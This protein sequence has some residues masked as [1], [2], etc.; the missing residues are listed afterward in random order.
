MTDK[1]F[2]HLHVHTEFSLLDGSAK[3]AELPKR[4]AELGM[5]SLAITDHGAMY[6]V[7]DFYKA[8]HAEG[9]K[10]ILGCE[11]YVASGSCTDK[12]PS[13]ENFY[14]HL[15]LLAEN[16]E[17]YHNLVK[18]V[19]YGFKEGFYYRPRI[20]LAVLRQYKT[21]LIALSACLGGPVAKDFLDKG[22]DRAKETA[23]VYDEI[24]GRGNFYLELQDHGMDEQAQLN[25]ELIRMSEETG[26]PL[27]ATND[28][29]YIFEDDAE[30][31]DILLCIQ[32]NKTVNDPDRMS[33]PGGGFYL[34]SPEEMRKKFA[35]I[36]IALENT[37]EIADRC[38]VEIRFNEYKLPKFP[39]PDNLTADGYLRQLCEAALPVKY[40]EQANEVT[41]RL[42]HELSVIGKMGYA[43]YF[44][45][46]W[47]AVKFARDNDINIGVRGSGNGCVVNYLLDITTVDPYRFNIIFERFLNPERISMPDIDLDIC[48]ERRGEVIDYVNR[49]Y[50]EDHVAQIITFGTMAAKASVRDVGRALAMPYGD[51]DRL[52][53]MI[54][55]GADLK[56]ALE[57]NKDLKARYDAEPPIR[58]LITMA[59]KLEGLPRHASTHAAGVLVCDRP[60]DDYIPLNTNDGLITTQFTMNTLEELGLLKFDFLGLRTLTVIKK[61]IDEVKRRHNV[62]VD[63]ATMDYGDKRV[64]DSISKANTE[65]VFQLESGGMKSFMKELRPSSLDDICA[66]IALYRPGPMDFIPK[67]V[68]NKNGGAVRYTHK[69]L[70]PILRETYGC[71]VYQ[72]QVI[73]IVRD[74][75]GYSYGR[76]D[77]IRRA[78]SKKKADVMAMEKN[79][80]I[81]GLND[82]ENS[83]PGCVANG[84]PREIAERIWDE[85]EDFARYAFPKGHS[86]GYAYLVY[87]T[88]WL[89][90]HYP[91]EYMS[92]LLSSV[93]DSPSSV[94]AYI[95]ECKK[96]NLQVSPPDVNRS[97]GRFTADKNAI[98]FGLNAIKNVGRQT[99]NAIVKERERGPYKSLSDF[100]SRMDSQY[101]NKRAMECLIRA[102]A[103]DSLGGKRSQYI[104]VFAALMDSSSDTKKNVLEGQVSLFDLMSSDEQEQNLADD[105]PN[106]PEFPDSLRLSDEKEMLGIYV[107]GHPYL[108]YEGLYSSK[109]TATSRDFMA[110]A[111]DGGDPNEIGESVL[112]EDNASCTVGGII[113]SKTTKYTKKNEAM[114][115]VTIEDMYGEVEL[116][117]FPNLFAKYEL[118]L[119][120]GTAIL[121]MGRASVREGEAAKVVCNDIRI[122][123]ATAEEKAYDELWLKLAKDTTVPY[124]K[125]LETLQKHPGKNP[126][127]AYDEKTRQRLNI[128]VEY[129]ANADDVKLILS[130]K[131]LLGDKNVVVKT[132]NKGV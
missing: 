8:C 123:Q 37:A 71:I 52:A 84:I 89:K 92:A 131:A 12:T 46:V 53:K 112:I 101:L 64:Y 6:G 76:G 56:S 40:R 16:N 125:I 51:V 100:I 99:V 69:S 66:G 42:D 96:M 124:S 90:Y 122:M 22:Y 45:V 65:G 20:D 93:L 75:A 70:E 41:S 47:D 18:L 3:I 19:S 83:V 9:V 14:Y 82:D 77:L 98:I 23:L 118:Q 57:I 26:I 36:P 117:V 1:N 78:M 130:L 49:T 68:R 63:P 4:A 21:G 44:L 48:Y 50:G 95:S 104:S 30:S 39:L 27:V 86:A 129:N 29:H 106:I 85:M 119:A 102:G 81:N 132:V 38:N 87:Q 15:V 5:T 120:T 55:F 113:T 114:A 127:I 73:Q 126:V 60:V 31:H 74:L 7:I 116:I 107:S 67:F 13:K 28:V 11:V 43:M 10:P 24:F 109:I 72:E 80:F 88:A 61:T 59:M 54:P 94:S 17:G 105:L 32:T 97:F 110:Q 79:Y 2:S 25:P 128:S 35:H 91:L 103:L 62:V 108:T 121:A 33:Y 34:T 115:F 58:H 111:E